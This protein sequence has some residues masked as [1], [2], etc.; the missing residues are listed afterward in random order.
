MPVCRGS[1]ARAAARLFER[2]LTDARDRRRD[3]EPE[4][5]R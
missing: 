4:E 2:A 1:S 5:H 3:K